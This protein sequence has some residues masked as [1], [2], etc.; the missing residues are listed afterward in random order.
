MVG[1]A[2]IWHITLETTAGLWMMLATLTYTIPSLFI[3]LWAGV[4]ADRYNRRHIIMA[5]DACVALATLAV[6]I[7]FWCGLKNL[8]LLLLAS[9]FRSF[10]VG[11]QTPAVNA[12]YPQ[13]VPAEKLARV[14]GLNQ[15]LTSFLM[16]LAPVAGGLI[17]SLT[18]L[19]T[20]F[21]VDVV[22]ALAAIIILGLTDIPQTGPEA[23]KSTFNEMGEGLRYVWGHRPIR[24]LI[25]CA[26]AFFFLVTPAMVL[27][28]LLVARSFGP[29]VWR[30]TANEAVWSGASLFGGLY[31][32]RHGD[33]KDKP[34]VLALCMATF[35]LL[36]G[37][38]GLA[39]TF[40]LFLVL[41]GLAGFFFPLFITAETVFIQQKAEPAKLGRV[42]SISQILG[43]SAM[44]A[45][46]LIFG[47]LA[48]IVSVETLLIVS[49]VMMI[50]VGGLYF[51]ASRRNA[52]AEA[53][54]PAA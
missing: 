50:A 37:L 18:G 22:T 47:P 45:S 53:G 9:T 38:M 1:Y 48:D 44:P 14:Q 35:G 26:A 3:S 40:V 41:M 17:L 8:E 51:K 20:A 24:L 42:F 16:L 2:I 7:A 23:K 33:F 52:K 31:V 27:T 11:V 43:N 49:G 54:P 21:L 5:A 6:A 10:G 34:A 29:E 46:I 19:E 25:L 15:S 13:L 32:A 36:F 39:W 30:L 12:I 4:W 28:P